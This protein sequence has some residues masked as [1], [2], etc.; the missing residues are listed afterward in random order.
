LLIVVHR[1]NRHAAELQPL[2]GR[3]APLALRLRPYNGAAG[4][5]RWLCGLLAPLASA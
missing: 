3:F 1:F 4:F 5:A 2:Y